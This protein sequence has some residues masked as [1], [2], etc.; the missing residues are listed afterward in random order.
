MR[1][2]NAPRDRTPPVT[3]IA[4]DPA[5]PDGRYSG[6]VN[7]AVSAADEA[8][9]S[10]V[11]ETRCVLDPASPP[12]TFDELPSTPC[13]Y[14]GAGAA[15]AGDGAHKLFAAS[16]DNAGNIESPVVERAFQITRPTVAPT[17]APAPTPVP[18]AAVASLG[19]QADKLELT[20]VFPLGGRTRLLG[21]APS[22]SAGRTV[23]L[24]S[25]WDRKQVAR[26]TVGPDLTFSTTAPL[27]PRSLRLTNKARYEAQIGS[28]KSRRLKFARRMYTTDLRISGRSVRFAGSVTAPLAKPIQQITIVAAGSCTGIAR[29]AVAARVKPNRRGRFSATFSLPPS[30]AGLPVVFL[31]AQTKVP[32]N[33]ASR[34]SFPTFTLIRSVRSG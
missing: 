8:G 31:R 26:A 2:Y 13:P 14:L 22:G 27:P 25:T 20:D 5:A 19:C 21:V 18:Q 10:G 16:R 17:P 6:P 30:L 33:A 24:F 12:A 15:V 23:T 3:T 9:G 7:A 4:L 11:A 32:K 29:G 1:R 28:Q 34:K